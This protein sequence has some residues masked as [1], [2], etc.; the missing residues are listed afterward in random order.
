LKSYVARVLTL[1]GRIKSNMGETEA[2]AAS[3]GTQGFLNDAQA[4]QTR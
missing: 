2:V 4:D 1:G 3:G